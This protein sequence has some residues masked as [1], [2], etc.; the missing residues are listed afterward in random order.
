MRSNWIMAIALVV[1]I[2]FF[3]GCSSE[4][5]DSSQ[6]AAEAGDL[7]ARVEDWS[8][9]KADVD[10]LVEQ[11]P[12]HQRA[13]YQT[14]RGR[15]ELVDIMIEEELYHQEGLRLG[16]DE[17]P[18]IMAALEAY[19]RGLVVTEYFRRHVETRAVPSE[20]EN[21]DFYDQNKENYTKQPIVRAQHIFSTDREK[22]VEFK[23]R[24]E[25]GE[26]MTAL[27][28]KFSEDE[29]T[30][31][32]GGDLGYFNPD[33]YIRS[34]GYSKELSEAAFS[35]TP[36]VV[37]DPIKW[38]R[39][40]SLL[41]VNE[42]RPAELRTYEEVKEDIRQMFKQRRIE[43]VKHEVFEELKPNYD[44]ENLIAESLRTEERSDEELWQWAQESTDP[45]HR[46]RA[47]GDIVANFPESKHA[48]EALFMIGFVYA[49]ELKDVVEADR[50]FTRVVNEYPD[51]EVARNAEWMLKNLNKPLPEFE[52][53]DELTE[54]IKN[55]E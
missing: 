28:M 44:T 14:R 27:A 34:A 20:E 47:Y 55:S 24:I 46:L 52:D 13:K 22:L 30:R 11:M 54:K 21:Y 6:S 7:A 10:A 41:R 29:Q 31:G 15:A 26:K 39:G 8:V 5:Q 4:S 19:K 53:L 2:G 12:E 16:L 37:S 33:G 23:K 3:I 17:D 18:A 42:Y 40:Y 48:A 49:E 43:S 1:T 25:E 45:Y 32:D 38:E 50:T 9:T 35:M 51:S 36:G